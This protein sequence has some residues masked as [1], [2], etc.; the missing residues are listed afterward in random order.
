MVP[1]NAV[2]PSVPLHIIRDNL[3]TAGF[4]DCKQGIPLELDLDL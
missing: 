2:I 1:Y 3:G 4:N